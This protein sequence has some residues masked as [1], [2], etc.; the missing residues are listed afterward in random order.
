[1]KKT[2]LPFVTLGLAYSAAEAK[3]SESLYLAN[4]HAKASAVDHVSDRMRL[5]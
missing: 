2:I 3:L 5:G 4:E 1:M